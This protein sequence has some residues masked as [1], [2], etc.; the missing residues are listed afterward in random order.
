MLSVLT[1]VLIL[2]AIIALAWLGAWWLK[3]RGTAEAG[4]FTNIVVFVGFLFGFLLTTLQVFATNHYS[5]ARSEAQAE[6]TSLVTMYDDLGGFPSHARRRGERILICYMWSVAASDWKAQE[7]GDTQE[8]S[9]ALVWGGRLR[10][11]RNRLPQ[12]DPETQRVSV[13]VANAGN[14]RQQ[15]LF[16]ARPQIPAILWV[17]VFVS[18]GLLIFLQ[19]SDANSQRKIVWRATLIAVI[20]VMTLEVASL[21]VLDRPFSP[22]ARIHPSAMTDAIGLLTAGRNDLPTLRECNLAG[23]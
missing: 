4:Q 10:S 2:W 8:S 9:D 21:A 7:R 5:D 1:Y 15:L 22:V 14:A 18:G 13:D 23:W 19:V 6:P 3:R 17:V 12:D 11:F 20:V 16:L